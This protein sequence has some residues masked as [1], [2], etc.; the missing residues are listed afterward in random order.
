MPTRS[1]A[2][3]IGYG[4]RPLLTWEADLIVGTAGSR[5]PTEVRPSAA[6]LRGLRLAVESFDEAIEGNGVG[7]MAWP[8]CCLVR[9]SWLLRCVW[10][11][12]CGPRLDP[13]SPRWRLRSCRAELFS[14]DAVRA[15]WNIVRRELE[16]H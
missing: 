2:V 9:T 4:L 1:T 11:W 3:R 15:T 10:V 6:R 12:L 14:R 13:P 8:C 5:A 7:S 16:T